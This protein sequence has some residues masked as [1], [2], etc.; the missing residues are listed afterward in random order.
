MTAESQSSLIEPNRTV[1][2]RFERV[3]LREIDLNIT[4][5]CNLNCRHCAFASHLNDANELPLEVIHS[6]LRDAESLGCREIHLTGGEPT[7]HRQFEEVLASVID[8]GFFT[9]LISNGTCSKAKLLRYHAIGLRHLLFSLDGMANMHDIIRGR[10]G[11]FDVT[12]GRMRDALELGYHVRI[13]AVA[14]N[15]NLDELL[16]LYQMCACDGVHLFSVFLYSPTGRDAGEQHHQIINA[17]R[18]REFKY[19][20]QAIAQ[21]HETEV[22]AEKGFHFRDEPPLDWA[23]MSGRGGGCF[24]LSRVMDYLL[25]T[26]KGEVFPCALLNDKGIPYGNVYER[27]LIDIINNPSE[28]YLTYEGFREADGKCRSCSEWSH[29]HGG[30]RSFVKAFHGHWK[31]P[32]PQCTSR[33]GE[34]PEYIPLCPLFKEH[35]RH[36][37]VSGFSESLS[38]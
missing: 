26:G 35:L 28:H 20:L 8:H 27:S 22:F 1:A 12:V 14:M 6:I 36:G 18:W 3:K 9:R 2:S 15:D 4:N 32:D 29:C 10:Q 33:P 21:A 37:G 13:N 19:E 38:E 23:A 30:C 17:E 24:H 11:L 25:I 34:I 16:S 7:I 31:E 5:R